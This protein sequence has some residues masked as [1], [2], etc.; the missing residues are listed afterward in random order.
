M[1][2]TKP[3]FDLEMKKN[4]LGDRFFILIMNDDTRDLM[5]DPIC[6]QKCKHTI[7]GKFFIC[8]EDYK[9]FC[10]DCETNIPDEQNLSKVG[11]WGLCS[12]DSKRTGKR[13]D[14]HN[15]LCIHRIE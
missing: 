10:N 2:I 3:R 9:W 15:H 4:E 6:C 1:E 12:N 14:T 7:N 5:G 8:E 13:G 11:Q